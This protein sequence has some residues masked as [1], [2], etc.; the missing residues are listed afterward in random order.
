MS[1]TQEDGA[2]MN[3]VME[4]AWLIMALIS[5][6]LADHP[7]VRANRTFRV[8]TD[9]SRKALFEL[10]REAEA[11]CPDAAQNDRS[12]RD[13]LT[14]EM[15]ADCFGGKLLRRKGSIPPEVRLG[16]WDVGSR[17][18]KRGSDRHKK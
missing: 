12:N 1:K 10:H 13:A 16:D 17:G 8:L 7:T 18:R 6:A 2:K 3:Q 15:S 9:K 14:S 4:R 11:A 5:S